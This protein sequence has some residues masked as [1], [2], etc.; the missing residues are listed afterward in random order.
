[1]SKLIDHWLCALLFGEKQKWR[2]PR[3]LV[4]LCRSHVA[5]P[6]N[7]AEK[8]ACNG[9]WRRQTKLIDSGTLNTRAPG[10][11][12]SLSPAYL[13]ARVQEQGIHEVNVNI[14]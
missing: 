9:H 12:C 14:E 10:F 4:Q 2:S 13:A 11:C 7:L 6:C 8:I 3:V 1:M 5:C